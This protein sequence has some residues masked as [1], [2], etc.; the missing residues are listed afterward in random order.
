MLAKFQKKICGFFLGGGFE[1]S[2]K[3]NVNGYKWG[4]YT[5]PIDGLKFDGKL[6]DE[7]TPA[8]FGGSFPTRARGSNSV[9]TNVV[10]T[11][12]V[13]VP[14]GTQTSVFGHPV[15]LALASGKSHSFSR[16]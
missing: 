2:Q 3:K 16:H 9:C 8:G 15:G 14:N 5:T 11:R 4:G 7:K 6:I 10:V 12:A 1:I 13:E